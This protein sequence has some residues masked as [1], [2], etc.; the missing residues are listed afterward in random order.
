M[1]EIFEHRT[2]LPAPAGEVFRWHAEPGALQR[3][4]PPWER[5]EVV[6][7]GRIEKGTEVVLRVGVGPLSLPWI[8][9]IVECVPGRCFRD[10]QVRGP[11]ARWEHE[12]LMEPDGPAACWLVDRITYS[13]PFG[14]LGRWL[15]GRFVR[16][17]LQ[18][19][20]DYRHSLTEEA[21]AGWRAARRLAVA[22]VL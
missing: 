8:A 3:L 14:G 7:E 12:H 1:N 19:M 20:F 22:G 11:F 4:T 5:A 17:K 2:W 16:V 18:R 9:R 21:F 10:I 15:G 6:R 13:L